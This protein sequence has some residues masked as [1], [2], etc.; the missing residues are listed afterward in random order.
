[1]FKFNFDSENTTEESTTNET[2]V[3]ENTVWIDAK[4]VFLQDCID[5]KEYLGDDTSLLLSTTIGNTIIKYLSTTEIINLLSKSNS[6]VLKAEQDHSDLVTS[7]YEGGLKIWNGTFDLLEY[8]NKE[9]V[10]FSNM[11]VLDLG[12]GN[13]LLGI[14]ALLN[15]AANV[16]FQDYNEEVIKNITMPNIYVNTSTLHENCKF[17][18]G[19][20]KTFIEKLPANHF[21]FILTADTIYNYDN[22]EKIHA[23]FK[24]LLK[25]SGKIY[26]AAKTVYFGLSGGMRKFESLFKEKEVFESKNVFAI[27]DG[28]QR[29]IIEIK[30]R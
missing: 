7:V 14:Y 25:K 10:S 27:M 15:G 8:L 20:W 3:S 22:Y 4:E 18:A 29:E 21:D 1:M 26:L 17:F 23:V 13:G 5:Y 6:L 16:T 19:D 24:N 30:Y 28:I 2:D 11:N 9:N 12:C